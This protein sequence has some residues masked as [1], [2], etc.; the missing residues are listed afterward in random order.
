MAFV[1][2]LHLIHIADVVY[3]CHD[4]YGQGS[5]IRTKSNIPLKIL[6]SQTKIC[7]DNDHLFNSCEFSQACPSGS[8]NLGIEFQKSRSVTARNTRCHALFSEERLHR[9]CRQWLSTE[10]ADNGSLGFPIEGDI[11]EPGGRFDVGDAGSAA[12]AGAYPGRWLAL[13]HLPPLVHQKAEE[14]HLFFAM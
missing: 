7:T 3:T 11:V 10:S 5:K 2:T 14:D 1:C 8:Q 9:K 4:Q 6:T 13:L 12:T